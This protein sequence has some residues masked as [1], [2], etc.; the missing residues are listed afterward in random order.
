MQLS[1]IKG[2]LEF[3]E[4]VILNLTGNDTHK[5]QTVLCSPSHRTLHFE[6]AVDIRQD[7]AYY[8]WL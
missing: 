6:Y 2:C 8:L 1:L 7:L 3:L 4:A 5:P